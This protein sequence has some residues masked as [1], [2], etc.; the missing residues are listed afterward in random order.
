MFS[1]WQ[2]L[3][4]Y[5]NGLDGALQALQQEIRN[6]PAELKLRVV[7]FQLLALLGQWP[8]ALAQL[9]VIAKLDAAQTPLA[10]TY[11][12]ALRAEVFRTEVFAGKKKPH[13]LGEPKAWV[14]QLIEALQQDQQGQRDLAMSLRLDALEAAPEIKGRAGEHEFDWI[15][16]G[17]VRLGPTL[18]AVIHGQ[19]YWLAFDQIAHVRI[20]APADLRD[21]VWAQARITLINE[22]EILALLPARY[23]DLAGEDDLI[24]L[25]R[26]TDWQQIAED[27]Y[28]GRGQKMWITDQAEYALLDV[29]E[30]HFAA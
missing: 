27:M 12:S 26:K 16:D 30:L 28:F 23:P 22:G 19:Y 13:I 21:L 7:L 11:R 18:E 25:S 14:A 15:A 8:R 1:S 29:R 6:R 10:Q 9:Q 3:T 4:Q 5:P 2:E 20:E 17:D 24:R